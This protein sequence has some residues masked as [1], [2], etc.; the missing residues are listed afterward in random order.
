[1]VSQIFKPV[2]VG[3]ALVQ[4]VVEGHGW[5]HDLTARK[6]PSRLAKGK[7]E[8]LSLMTGYSKSAINFGLL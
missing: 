7:P 2:A 4:I 5:F 1:M 3:Q 6:C 8:A